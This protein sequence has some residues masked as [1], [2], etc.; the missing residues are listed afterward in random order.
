MD[1]H[2]HF[3]SVVD[4]NCGIEGDDDSL[5]L[6]GGKNSTA[7]VNLKDACPLLNVKLKRQK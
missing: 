2:D 1:H 6:T 7:F 4:A 5:G 3:S